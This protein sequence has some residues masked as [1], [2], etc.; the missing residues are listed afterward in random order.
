MS[1]A[2]KKG[3][4]LSF[5]GCVGF[6][7]IQ[8]TIL[9]QIKQALMTAIQNPNN[10]VVI[11]GSSWSSLLI[12]D[13]LREINTQ[14]LEKY[15]FYDSVMGETG[16]FSCLKN[17]NYFKWLL[18]SGNNINSN[19]LQAFLDQRYSV[20]PKNSSNISWMIPLFDITEDVTFMFTDQGS[21]K[22][23]VI[24]D[25]QSTLSS[26]DAA[27]PQPTQDVVL[28]H[29][30]IAASSMSIPGTLMSD[31]IKRYT[32]TDPSIKDAAPKERKFCDGLLTYNNMIVRGFLDVVNK[33][34]EINDWTAISIGA[35]ICEPV[36]PKWESLK[37]AGMIQW[38]KYLLP[39]FLRSEESRI[40]QQMRDMESITEQLNGDFKLKFYNLVPKITPDIFS[41]WSAF[42]GTGTVPDCFTLNHGLE[43]NKKWY[44][45]T[46]IQD[47][48]VYLT[49][50]NDKIFS[51]N[52]TPLN[53]QNALKAIKDIL[54]KN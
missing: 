19:K 20:L 11:V 40:E 16:L 27:I 33:Y 29:S 4:L 8:A 43:I 24:P 47:N 18:L 5:S 7:G 22:D 45:K 36:H 39:L 49:L 6:M 31:S 2:S 35:P 37:S 15:N 48:S 12:L 25:N 46:L 42:L 9:D 1:D 54:T 41:S 52:E 32:F 30:E 50:D 23:A 28:T 17:S 26:K 53:N 21:W 14:S 38:V 44:Q 51:N 3:I 34:P 13:I 10:K